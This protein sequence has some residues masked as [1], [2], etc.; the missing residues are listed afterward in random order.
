MRKIILDNTGSNYNGRGIVISK[1]KKDDVRYLCKFLTTKFC[2]SSREDDMAAGMVHVAY[3]MCIEKK[4]VDLC[5]ILRIQ[6]FEN[7]EKIKK[8]KY[9]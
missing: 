8:A 2:G 5:E 4:Q 6:L 3:L 7:L 9:T 1:I